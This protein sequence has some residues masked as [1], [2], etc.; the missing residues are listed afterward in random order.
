MWVAVGVILAVRLW[1]KRLAMIEVNG[2]P[3]GGADQANAVA[4][5][6]VPA[7][8]IGAPPAEQDIEFQLSVNAQGRLVTEE[9]FGEIIIAT[10]PDGGILRLR[11]VARIELGS[12]LYTMVGRIGGAPAAVI[13][14]YQ[15]PGSNALAVAD[16]LVAAGHDAD[17]I[18]YVGAQRGIETRL[19]PETPYAH[20][21]LDV[22]GA[23][24]VNQGFGHL[25]REP[26]LN[27]GALGIKI[28]DS[29]HLTQ[30]NDA[31]FAQV[32]DVC[33]TYDRH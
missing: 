18:R 25:A 27:L 30:S 2:L 26:L 5:W 19:L 17:T 3:V 1:G 8:V 11:D 4:I 22:V 24:R 6:A 13:A 12:Q 9:E 32:G 28:H 10:A 29:V 31:V 15:T 21:F 14:I 33:T 20:E 16:A 7:G 23:Q